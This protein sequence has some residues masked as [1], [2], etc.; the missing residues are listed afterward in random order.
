VSVAVNQAL[1][2]PRGYYELLLGAE[3]Q[4]PHRRMGSI[5]AD[6]HIRRQGCSVT[7][8]CLDRVLALIESL[9]AGVEAG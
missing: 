9:D 2:P 7:Q 4:P 6:D 5:A 1:Y 8:R 3:H